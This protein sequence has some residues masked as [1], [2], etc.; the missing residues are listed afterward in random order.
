MRAPLHAASCCA[1]TIVH[2]RIDMYLHCRVPTFPVDTHIHRLAQ[3]W[4][5]TSGRSVIE[6]EQDLKAVFP[7]ADW[8]ASPDMLG[9]VALASLVVLTLLLQHALLAARPLVM[10]WSTAALLS[11]PVA[12][13]LLPV[14]KS[15]LACP[16]GC[17]S[18]PVLQECASP[19]YIAVRPS[20]LPCHAARPLYLL[21]LLLGSCAAMGSVRCCIKTARP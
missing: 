9:A 8:C 19:A 12:G 1:S 11:S 14:S 17:H 5:L 10:P 13:S 16:A 15:L 21:H 18:M 2:W 6:T 4:G 7:A 3:R 20:T